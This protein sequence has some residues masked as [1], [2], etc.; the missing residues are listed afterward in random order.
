M[1]NAH[2]IKWCR[3]NCWLAMQL[4]KQLAQLHWATQERLEAKK[5][6]RGDIQS[7][8]TG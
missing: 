2:V 8:L 6:L 5:A 3:F 4:N 7:H 1:D